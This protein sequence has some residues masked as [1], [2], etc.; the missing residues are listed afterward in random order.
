MDL[1]AL[2]PDCLDGADE[3]ARR[4]IERLRSRGPQLDGKASYR[5]PL[6][7]AERFAEAEPP[8]AARMALL[9]GRKDGFQSQIE[10]CRLW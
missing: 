8:V 4:E 5:L 1:R 10:E 7:F 9:I 6:R 3:L 2:G